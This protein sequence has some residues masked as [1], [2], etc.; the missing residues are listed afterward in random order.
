MT[1]EEKITMVRVMTD[2]DTLPDAVIMV[3][4][5]I[6]EE[7]IVHRLFPFGVRGNKEEI[8]SSYALTE[9]ELAKRLILRQGGEG[10]L[11][12]SENGISRTYASVDD[13]DILSRIT[14]F[15]RLV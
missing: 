10:E 7:K 14:P 2:D 12:H 15:A 5:K 11:A 9:C 8:L 6:A 3:F 4:L 1:N 13:E